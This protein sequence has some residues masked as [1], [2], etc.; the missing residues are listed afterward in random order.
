MKV[1]DIIDVKWLPGYGPN[2][3]PSERITT[4]IIGAYDNELIILYEDGWVVEERELESFFIDRKFLGRNAWSI[5]LSEI[6]KISTV[7]SV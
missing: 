7:T 3:E 6:E 5:L 1:G 4:E 2:S